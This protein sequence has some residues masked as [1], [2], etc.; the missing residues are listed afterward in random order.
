MFL[1]VLRH[2]T[3]ASILKHGFDFDKIIYNFDFATSHTT[4]F[5]KEIFIVGLVYM[6]LNLN[7]LLIMIYIIDCTKKRLKGHLLIKTN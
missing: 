7:V 3:K 5:L 6:I 1:T 2:Y 4:G